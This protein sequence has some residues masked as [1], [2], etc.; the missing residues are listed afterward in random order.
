MNL[1]RWLV[2]LNRLRSK[3]TLYTKSLN[4]LGWRF[5]INITIGDIY[6]FLDCPNDRLLK[7]YWICSRLSS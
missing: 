1:N 2:A 5:W 6:A 3:K 4:C 7:P